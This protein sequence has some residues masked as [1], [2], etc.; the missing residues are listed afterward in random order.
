MSM[1]KHKKMYGEEEE[2]AAAARVVVE[3]AESCGEG[4]ELESEK[5]ISLAFL[6]MI[7]S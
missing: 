7:D 5:P 4:F 6:S 2:E 1:N 3:S